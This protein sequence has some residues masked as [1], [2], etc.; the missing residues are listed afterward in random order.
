MAE[1]ITISKLDPPLASMNY[2]QL[3]EL[4]LTHIQK[5]SG[6]IWSDNNAH[7]PGIT[8]L[9]VL[10]YA[11]TD[12]GYRTNYDIRDILA[13][14]VPGT[15]IHNFF[16][17][18]QI[19]PNC[20]VTFNDYRKLLMDVVV[21]ETIGLDT[22]RYGVKNAWLTKSN[23]NEIPFFVDHGSKSLSF[24]KLIPES[25]RVIPNVLYD[26][27]LE[28]DQNETYGD[29]N[30]NV[31]S[32]T[33]S[34]QSGIFVG[35]RIQI[36]VEFPLWDTVGVDWND[37]TSMFPYVKNVILNFSRVPDEFQIQATGIDSA[38]Q[39]W[40]NI[41]LSNG[42]SLSMGQDAAVTALAVLINE[43]IYDAAGSYQN[44]MAAFYLR[45]VAAVN[46]VL[47]AARA[48]IHANRNLCEDFFRFKALKVEEIAVC[49]DIDLKTDADVETVQADILHQIERFLAPTVY[50]R[51]LSEMVERGYTTDQIFEGPMLQHGF[52]DE[53]ELEVSQTRKTLH[54][55]DLISIIMDIPGVEAVRSIQVA[56]IPLDN[57]EAIPTKQVRWCLNLSFDKGYIPRLGINRSRFTFFKEQLP[58]IA[59]G[60]EAQEKLDA[61]EALDRPQKLFG[62]PLDYEIPEGEYKNLGEY[63]SLQNDFPLLYGIGDAGLPSTATLERKNQARQLKAFLLFFEQIL[64]NYLAQLEHIKDVFSLDGSRQVNGQFTIDK[65]YFSQALIHLVPNAVELYQSAGNPVDD[66]IHAANLQN[67]T[68]DQAGFEARRNKI[69]DHLAARFG[70]SFTDY[71]LLV[72]NIDG[73]KAPD[74]L[75]EDKL[76]LLNNYPLISSARGKG[77]NYLDPA[78][79]WHIDN[80][81]GVARRVRALTGIDPIKISTLTFTPRLAIEA[82]GAQF[83]ISIYNVPVAT[84]PPFVSMDLVMQATDLYDTQDEAKL[85]LE[86]LVVNGVQPRQYV[87]AENIASVWTPID[88]YLA[89]PVTANVRPAIVADGKVI[90][91][92]TSPSATYA[93]R[94]SAEAAL[95]AFRT[96]VLPLFENDYQS[97]IASNRA[98]L[99]CDFSTVF[100]D[101]ELVP[102]PQLGPCPSNQTQWFYIVD[103]LSPDGS[104]DICT[105]ERMLADPGE[106]M[107]EHF[108]RVNVSKRMETLGWAARPENYDFVWNPVIDCPVPPVS[109]LLPA[110][111]LRDR[112]HDIR[113]MFTTTLIGEFMNSYLAPT[114]IFKIEDSSF[115]DGSKTLASAAYDQAD[116][117]NILVNITSTVDTQVVDG[118][119]IFI[120]DAMVNAVS[121]AFNAIDVGEDFIDYVDEGFKIQIN[122]G[123]GSDEFTIVSAQSLGS[124]TSRLFIQEPLPTGTYVGNNSTLMMELPIVDYRIDTIN[125]TQGFLVKFTPLDRFIARVTGWVFDT[126]FNREGF[127][128]VEHILLRPKS[129]VTELY[130]ISQFA[131]NPTTPGG[132]NGELV[133]S[134]NITILEVNN[135]NKTFKIQGVFTDELIQRTDI[136]VVGSNGNDGFYTVRS[137]TDNGTDTTITVYEAFYS[138]DDT[139]GT[140]QFWKRYAI[141][142]VNAGANTLTIVDA[143]HPASGF[144]S[145][146]NEIIVEGA[147]PE[148]NNGRYALVG[149]PT[150]SGSQYTFA[151]AY[152]RVPLREEFLPIDLEADCK[153]CVL[154][155]PYSFVATVVLPAWAGRFSN[156]NFRRFFE[157]TVRLETPAH[158]LVNICWVTCESM[159]DF[160][161]KWRKWLVENTQGANRPAYTQAHRELL[162]SIDRLRSVYASGT[163]HDC[164]TDDEMQHSIILNNSVLGTL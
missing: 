47:D 17:A 83:T 141:S 140:V 29:L 65:T 27:L 9:E 66:A 97:L 63:F 8:M 98:N 32:K 153:S 160:E 103:L 138:E 144:T 132:S 84:I 114:G 124:G 92:G 54:V 131:L 137:A 18:A 157:R 25:P 101:S 135:L 110:I 120:I 35:T 81:S 62:T 37:V 100:T 164:D 55:S 130:P 46:R 56:N 79:L 109:P 115:N 147:D 123:S 53:V 49:A 99:A 78:K 73:K 71:A 64:A 91:I 152:K 106:S 48:R 161:I 44:G 146:T 21:E 52:V 75:I 149:D 45:K 155:D 11:I 76:A 163:L 104:V 116:P 51:S 40:L 28:L 3:R 162:E 10:A 105:Y 126:Y 86:L 77:F 26:V 4:G 159:L 143:I 107:A 68:E 94:S 50:F 2:A 96:L 154:T 39:V 150:P 13:P 145:I 127:H 85:A 1:P 142:N 59:D 5:L 24:E 87:M 6:K 108:A 7:D 88:P 16:T 33:I 15:D 80:I 70:E 69:L 38:G 14:A 113:G 129:T 119:L 118:K 57:D 82:V 31:M 58:F 133:F 102:E 136:R 125:S 139:P 128:V 156:Q 41:E 19:L 36:D 20:P 42:G 74:E 121:Y 43:T 22:I 93:S 95:V 151:L 23:D 67:I 158:I 112:C 12:L 90:A 30:S 111:V 148:T 34:V 60:L 89:Y 117:K 61:L 134:R 122:Y 72:Y